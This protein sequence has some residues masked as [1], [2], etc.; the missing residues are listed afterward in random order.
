MATAFSKLDPE[1][2]KKYGNV[3]TFLKDASPEEIAKF[4]SNYVL[5]EIENASNLV[6]SKIITNYAQLKD[7]WISILESAANIEKNKAKEIYETW[8]NTFDAIVAARKAAFS[9][10]SYAEALSDDEFGWLA[11]NYA[12]KADG[13][14]DFSGY[15]SFMY[16]KSDKRTLPEIGA[17]TTR[18][19]DADAID[20]YEVDANGNLVT[21]YFDRDTSVDEI[22]GR[23]NARMRREF[24]AGFAHSAG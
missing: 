13:K 20:A 6:G 18:K 24:E 11:L 3:E 1:T 7:D 4:Y 17:P 5:P 15:N 21:G 14:Y 19:I 22:Y 16:D 23:R 9:E 2:I 8:A 10:K 12:K